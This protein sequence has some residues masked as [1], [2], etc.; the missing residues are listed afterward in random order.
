MASNDPGAPGGGSVSPPPAP[1]KLTFWLRHQ[2][3]VCELE[4]T[5]WCLPVYDNPLLLHNQKSQS[6]NQNHLNNSSFQG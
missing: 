5:G 2:N 6:L 3:Q 4:N 1:R